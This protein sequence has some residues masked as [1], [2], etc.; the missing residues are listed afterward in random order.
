MGIRKISLTILMTAFAVSFACG[1]GKKAVD[2]A[3][4]SESV[5]E[6]I[7]S[8]S[9]EKESEV[10]VQEPE[11]SDSESEDDE[12]SYEEYEA[13]RQQRWQKV[14]ENLTL[15]DLDDAHPNPPEWDGFHEDGSMFFVAART[16][17][18]SA[19]LYCV[20]DDEYFIDGYMIL[21]IKDRIIPI[22]EMAEYGWGIGLFQG[23]FDKDGEDEYAVTINN[24]H[25]TGFYRE[26]LFVADPGEEEPICTLGVDGLQYDYELENIYPKVKSEY[27]ESTEELTYWLENNGSASA[28]ESVSLK[29]VF[30]EDEKYKE[31][32]FGDLF[33]I[34]FEDGQLGFI[35]RGGFVTDKRMGDYDYSLVLKGDFIY[36]DGNITCDNLRLEFEQ[37]Q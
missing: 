6:S 37:A 25:G 23:D 19:T 16:E 8:V 10:S 26:K 17:D 13:L 15:E 22:N 35:A 29:G 20:Y 4:V 31:M 21:R 9:E 33:S 11:T 24:G 1:C 27:D 30:E 12:M 7:S 34:T 32:L 36:K 2:S 18:E 5:S 3:S 28:K 14:V